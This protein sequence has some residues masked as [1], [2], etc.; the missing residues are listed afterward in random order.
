VLHEDASIWYLANRLGRRFLG[1][2][3]SLH[4]AAWREV[5]TMARATGKTLQIDLRPAIES[6]HRYE[7]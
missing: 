4:P 1:W 6:P 3:A 2:V 7:G 5:E